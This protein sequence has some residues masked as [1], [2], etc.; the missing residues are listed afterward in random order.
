[1]RP[2][3][4]VHALE[5][6]R[7]TT[8]SVVQMLEAA[9]G[10]SERGH[11]VAVVSRPGGDL[12]TVCAEAGVDFFA[13]ALTHE[14]DLAS[15]RKLRGLFR[16]RD[17]DVVHVH[18]G[19]PHAIAL[20]AAVG[21]GR[22][23]VLVVNRGVSFPL[24]LFNRWKYRHPRVGAV[25]CVAEAIREV[26]IRTAGVR[27]ERVHVIHAGT[28][29]R[30]FDPARVD[31]SGIR[32]ELGLGRDEVLV[33][34]VSVRDWKGW[35]ELAAAFAEVAPRHPAA[36]LLFVGC[37]PEPEREKVEAEAARLGIR[38]R[39]VLLPY[40]RDMPE[41]LGACDVVADASWAGTGITGTIREAMAMERAVVATDCAG[42]RELV[43]DR[44]AGLLVPQKDVTALAAALNELLEDPDLRRRLGR[45][46]RRRVVERFSTAVRLDRLEALYRS[47]CAGERSDLSAS[48]G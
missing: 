28:D 4:I 48:R 30:R 19:R 11:R 34:Q 8:G 41:V 6:N 38:D 16:E 15:A 20:L 43:T 42:N 3:S 23:P 2:L 12:E 33:G 32:R 9:R 21:L 39:L 31:P 10:L 47:L 24:D 7:L 5:K 45:A 44:E 13:L 36:R 22:R 29:T 26:V 40:R 46:A 18:K 37:E 14:F 25:V 1:M 35:R 27:P 17:V